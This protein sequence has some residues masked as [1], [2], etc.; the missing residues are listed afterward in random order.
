M[1]PCGYSSRAGTCIAGQIAQAIFE[2]GYYSKC[3][4]YSR[5]YGI[6]CTFNHPA[7]HFHLHNHG[8]HRRPD[9]HEYTVCHH[10]CILMNSRKQ[11]QVDTSGIMIKIVL[12]IESKYLNSIAVFVFLL[13]V[14]HSALL[15]ISLYR[16]AYLTFH[17]VILI[18]CLITS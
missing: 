10:R 17:M 9:E 6:Y 18:S 7:H 12:A 13:P 14:C 15:S 3:G 11:L 2:G 1:R 4:Y 5:K 16:Y 8:L